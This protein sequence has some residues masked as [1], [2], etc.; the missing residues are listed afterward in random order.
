MLATKLKK[1]LDDHHVK[2][3]TINH[4]PAYTAQEIAACAHVS[5]KEFAKTVMIKVD[6]ELKMMVEPANTH[7]DLNKLKE[8]TGAKSVELASEYEFQDKFPDCELGAMPPLGE[9]YHL[10]VYVSNKLRDDEKIV[11]NAGTHTELVK[12]KYKDFENLVK[13]TMIDD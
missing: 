12:M 8:V 9:M 3:I 2:Y 1:Y 6:G 11:F 4:S 5:G 13:P 10:D 7:V